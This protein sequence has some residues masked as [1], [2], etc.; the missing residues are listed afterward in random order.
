MVRLFIAASATA[1]ATLVVS[2][3]QAFVELRALC[4]TL[5]GGLRALSN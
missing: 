4:K 2:I 5:P 1:L 3:Y